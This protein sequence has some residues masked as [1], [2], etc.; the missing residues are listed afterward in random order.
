L[1]FFALLSVALSAASIAPGQETNP[2]NVAAV[3]NLNHQQEFTSS[4]SNSIFLPL[5]AK[6]EAEA[7]ALEAAR[8]RAEWRRVRL[9]AEAKARAEAEAQALKAARA[10]RLDAVRFRAWQKVGF[11]WMY[12]LGRGVQ[13]DFTSAVYWCRKAAEQG[14]AGAQHK[15]VLY[16]RITLLI[17]LVMCVWVT[18]KKRQ[19]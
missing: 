7:K 1:P 13:H 14:D 12:Q 9:A 3:A 11:G 4:P 5:K 10:A 8:L 2:P 19:A 16:C 17:V 15:L 6:A 18:W